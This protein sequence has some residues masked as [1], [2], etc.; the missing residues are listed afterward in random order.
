VKPLDTKTILE[1]AKRTGNVIVVEDHY[2][3]GGLGDAVSKTLTEHRVAVQ[4]S[5]LCVNHIPHSGDPAELMNWEKIDAEAIF[6][7]VAKS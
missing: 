4:Y 7:K 2:P 6:E 3:D 1:H 5:H